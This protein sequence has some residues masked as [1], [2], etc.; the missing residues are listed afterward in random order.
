MGTNQAMIDRGTA[1]H[2]Y[3]EKF[4]ERALDGEGRPILFIDELS[5]RFQEATAAVDA[6]SYQ[7][8]LT[9]FDAASYDIHGSFEPVLF[10]TMDD[11]LKLS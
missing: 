5:L 6:A 2:E 10:G 9:D 1:L 7:L 11:W 8:P 3:I 4:Y